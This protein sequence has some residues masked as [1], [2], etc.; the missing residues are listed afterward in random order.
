MNLPCIVAA[1]ML[2]VGSQAASSG[3][4]FSYK[5]NADGTA[6]ITGADAGLTEVVIPAVIDSHKVTAIGD[7]AF[8]GN[9]EML[10]VTVPGSVI[11]IGEYAFSGCLGLEE[12]KLPAGVESL[13][14]GCF[15]S[16]ISLKGIT[17]G[18]SIDSVPENCFTDC[19]SLKQI[20]L[21]K[22]VKSVGTDAFFGCTEMEIAYV[23]HTVTE[24]GKNSLGMHYGIRSGGVE[25]VSGFS[26]RTAPFAAAGVYA[27]ANGIDIESV[28]GDVNDD[29]SIDA[30]DASEVLAEYALLSNNEPS[31]FDAFMKY[32][33]DYDGDDCID[34]ADASQILVRY[35]ELQN[36][37]GNDW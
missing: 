29:G 28:L 33:G 22:S 14:K 24:I 1:V 21:P 26:I 17:L 18:E 4:G 31:E 34:A 37:G 3:S 27:Q 6:V 16:C 32:A 9:E 10:S 15:M 19:T 36:P 12:V 5:L 11:S 13:G 2:A 30:A 35:S 23:P 7:R 20:F 25:P 8:F